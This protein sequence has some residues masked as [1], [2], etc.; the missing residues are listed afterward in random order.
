MKN[1]TSVRKTIAIVVL[2][3]MLVMSFAQAEEYD[4]TGTWMNSTEL[5]DGK[6]IELIEIWPE[7]EQGDCYA[8]LTMLIWNEYGWLEDTRNLQ[9]KYT[10]IADDHVRAVF[11]NSKGF[12]IDIVDLTT[13]VD[14]AGYFEFIEDVDGNDYKVSYK[15]ISTYNEDAL[16][17]ILGKYT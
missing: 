12:L 15:R 9:G 11:Y 3:V 2:A 17:Y 8:T 6:I 14:F 1:G 13:T 4:F 5:S 16:A 10:Y 7:T